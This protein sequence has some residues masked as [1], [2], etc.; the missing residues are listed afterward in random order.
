MLKCNVCGQQLADPVYVS[1]GNLSVTS[2]CEMYAEP[3]EVFSCKHCSHTQ[4]RELADVSGYYDTCYKILIETEEEDQLYKIIDGQRVF[5]IEH[6]VNTLQHKIV[7]PEGARVLDYGCAKGASLK[8][9]VAMRPDITPCL[10]DVSEM[11]IPFWRKFT[12]PENW[13]TYT[14]RPDWRASFDLV[15]SYFAL[16][17]VAQPA[18]MLAT[19]FDLLKPGGCFYC[20][21]PNC[22]SNTADLVVIDHINHFSDESLRRLFAQAGFVSIDIDSR[23]HDGAFIVSGRRPLPGE[24]VLPYCEDRPRVTQLCQQIQEMA[25]YWQGIAA[26]IRAFEQAHSH[27]ARAAIYGSGFYG[28]FIAAALAEFATVECFLDQNPFRQGKQLLGR[29]IIAPEALPVGIEV[30]YVGLNPATARAT[31]T[32]VPMFQGRRLTFFYL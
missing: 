32:A 10:F 19:V 11:Y 21:V 27:G 29:P 17:H 14:P 7:I 28:T 18:G 23:S 5:R 12:C 1:G 31:I 15:T 9:L 30:L 26:H 16:E 3:T 2:L 25:A 13:A 24:S 22:Y 6:Q 4:S 8:R 20:I